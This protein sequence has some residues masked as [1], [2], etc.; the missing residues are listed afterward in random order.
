MK[1]EGPSRIANEFEGYLQLG[2]IEDASRLLADWRAMHEDSPDVAAAR[3]QL[4][5]AKK[6]WHAAHTLAL[7]FIGNHPSDSR[8]WFWIGYASRR[9]VSVRHAY[10][11]M[12]PASGRFPE[13]PLID[14]NFACYATIVE[15]FEEAKSALGRVFRSDVNWRMVAL[16][17]ADLIG[18]RDWIKAWPTE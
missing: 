4:A 6:E 5:S 1:S 18:L 3:C 12:H 7:E 13:M 16:E 11:A 9:A 10:S 8:A 15:E 2:M 17:D 14:Y